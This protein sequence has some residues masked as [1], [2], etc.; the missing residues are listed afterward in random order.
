M[1]A[2][3]E[4]KNR[5][6]IQ[7]KVKCIMEQETIIFFVYAWFLSQKRNNNVP[8]YVF[9]PVLSRFKQEICILLLLFKK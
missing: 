1:R 9:Y 6:I 3:L 8:I 7:W 5:I 2:T 4:N